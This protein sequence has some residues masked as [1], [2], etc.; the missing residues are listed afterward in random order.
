MAKQQ[1]NKQSSIQELLLRL[2]TSGVEG[3]WIQ[4]LEMFASTIVMVAR[5]YEQDRDRV[6]DCFLH[7]C[8]KLCENNFHRLLQFNTGRGASFRTW[9]IAVVSN[10]C[11]DW[12][13]ANSGRQ[14]PPAA[15]KKLS[16]MEQLVYRYKFERILDVETC[17]RVLQINYPQLRRKQLSVAIAN[18][19]ALLTPRQRWSLGFRR[20]R[21]RPGKA[22]TEPENQQD[23][24]IVTPGPGPELIAQRDQ[25]RDALLQAMSKLTHHQRLLLHLRFQQD[26]SL[27]DVARIAGLG[28]LHQARRRIESALKQLAELLPSGF[29]VA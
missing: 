26:L 13:R 3:A 1:T 24:E 25:D 4:F 29:S 27:K 7:V 8:E 22:L 18:I 14:R 15:I 20:G 12:H 23:N 2:Q 28:D 5:R 11:V 10:L 17:L 19:H 16:E 9:L 21:N 6:N